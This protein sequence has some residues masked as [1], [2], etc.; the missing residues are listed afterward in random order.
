MY[1]Q[2]KRV[3]KEGKGKLILREGE[4]IQNKFDG[5]FLKML[6]VYEPG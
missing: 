6:E 1:R 5:I 2:R 3:V 4:K